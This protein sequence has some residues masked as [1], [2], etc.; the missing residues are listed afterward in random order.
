MTIHKDGATISIA[1]AADWLATNSLV[2]SALG[3]RWLHP[4]GNRSEGRA[5]NSASAF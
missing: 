3:D 2:D 5:K 4:D 1:V